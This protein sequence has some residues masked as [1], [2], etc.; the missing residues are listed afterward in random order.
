MNIAHFY[1][2]VVHTHTHT[3]TH[4]SMFAKV[5]MQLPHPTVPSHI[6]PVTVY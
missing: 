3:H 4:T 2:P 1:I 5:S 6:A